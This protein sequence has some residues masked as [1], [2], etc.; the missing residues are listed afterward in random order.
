LLTAALDHAWKWWEFRISNG[1]QVLNFFLLAAAV[2]AAA[3]VSALGS[4]LHLV[5]AAVA[6]LGAA[7]SSAAYVVG[8]R[9]SDVAGL[10]VEPLR[11]IQARLAES[12][13]IE[14]LRMV[15]RYQGIQRRRL[16]GGRA[17]A[18]LMFPV[19]AVASTAA[20]VYAALSH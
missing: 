13:G 17:A 18:Q 10:A 9:Q 20:A 7:V 16:P 1:L 3:Y 5:V 14:T 19:A 12:L 15:D 11:E 2:M 6:V 8:K 4:H